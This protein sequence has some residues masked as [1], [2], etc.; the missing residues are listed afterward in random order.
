MNP[1]VLHDQHDDHEL[2]SMELGAEDLARSGDVEI[3][4]LERWHQSELARWL[5]ADALDEIA[6]YRRSVD[7]AREFAAAVRTARNP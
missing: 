7:A 4:R 2:A 6:R 5:G 3:L 1:Q